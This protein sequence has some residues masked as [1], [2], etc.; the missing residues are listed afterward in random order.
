MASRPLYLAIN[1]SDIPPKHLR[2]LTPRVMLWNED[3]WLMDLAPCLSYW[4]AKAKMTDRSLLELC[5]EV[6]KP[7]TSD[8]PRVGVAPHPWQAILLVHI[9]KEK[10]LKGFINY[11]SSFGRSLFQQLSWEIWWACTLEARDHLVKAG[12]KK[13]TLKNLNRE[14]RLMQR[15]IQK[16][17]LQQP[18]DLNHISALGIKRRFGP[19]IS[20]L[21]EWAFPQEI[22][23]GGEPFGSDFPFLPF[24]FSQRPQEKRNL[25]FPL[26][27][28]DHMEPLLQHDLNRLCQH[29][30]YSTGDLVTSLEW[31]LVLQD[32]S[33]LPIS[34]LFRHP[35]DLRRNSPLQQAALLQAFYN[36]EASSQQHFQH[37]N[38]AEI[39]P[40]P[41]VSW[42]LTM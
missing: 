5:Q 14:I 25:D 30:S 36:F 21:W 17:R 19:T 23:R 27:D 16:L 34:I 4:Q 28:W 26:M 41:V 40:P 12:Q 22:H 13:V 37:Y 7:L 42:K 15:A 11:A 1:Q 18:K 24:Q 10:S 6:L 31:C 3:T 35:H 8:S 20:T 32:M 39:P 2:S 38:D 33:E 29:P 9:L